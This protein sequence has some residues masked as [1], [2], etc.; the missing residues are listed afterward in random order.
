[1]WK[2]WVVSRAGWRARSHG[3]KK[4]DGVARCLFHSVW[5]VAGADKANNGQG[6]AEDIRSERAG[7]GPRR[8][9]AGVQREKETR[10]A[11]RD[12]CG[13]VIYAGGDAGDGC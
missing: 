7:H 11:T 12:G 5:A 13:Q 4:R 10:A 2:R 9:Q 1:M 3:G 8:E 6:L